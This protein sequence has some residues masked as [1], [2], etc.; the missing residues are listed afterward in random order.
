MACRRTAFAALFCIVF[1]ASALAQPGDRRL[2]T[3][4]RVLDL[5][6]P[7]D[8]G[9]GVYFLKLVLRYSDSHSQIVV[10]VRPGPASDPRG[11]PEVIRYTLSDMGAGDLSQLI[12]KMVANSP[13]VSDQEIA[14]KVKVIVTRSPIEREALSHALKGLEAIRISPRLADRVACDGSSEYEYWYDTWEES[15]HYTVTGP[16]K[17]SPQDELVQWMIKFREKLPDL[18]K[19]PAPDGSKLK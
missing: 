7:L 9:P 6:F 12:S 17:G 19:H 14:A 4:A 5:V 10:V 11:V 16:F 13:N 1:A 15:V 8:V 3:E 18:L 2:S